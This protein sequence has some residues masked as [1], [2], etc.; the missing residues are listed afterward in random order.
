MADNESVDRIVD[1]ILEDGE[2]EVSSILEKAERTASEILEKAR[3]MADEIGGK[4]L[5]EAEEKGDLARRRLL[6]SVNIEVKRAKLKA[7]EEIVSKINEEVERGLADARSETEYPEL[8][9]DLIVEAISG[10]EGDT[11]QVYVDRRDIGLLDEKVFRM[12]R[13][14]MAVESRDISGLEALVLEKSSLG[15]ARVGVP[16]GKVI[17]D[18]T[19]EARIYRLRDRTRNI[20]FEEV[21]EIEGSEG[22]GSA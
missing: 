2:K 11:F 13:E 5:R 3:N 17:F 6:S 18:N 1:Q 8:L 10:L 9:A 12:V 7:R 14:T 4:I 21:F 16:G 19:F 20:I 15:G 22:S